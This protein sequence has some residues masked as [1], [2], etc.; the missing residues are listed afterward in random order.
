MV[1]GKRFGRTF[2]L[3]RLAHLIAEL[4][5]QASLPGPTPTAM[6]TT[7]QLSRTFSLISLAHSTS[8]LGTQAP[9]LAVTVP[10]CPTPGTAPW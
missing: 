5:T 10:P 8:E 3:V 1:T 6:M 9:P 2:G 4:G 7:K